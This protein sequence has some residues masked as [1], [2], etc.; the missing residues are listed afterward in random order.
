MR[1]ILF[2]LLLDHPWQPFDADVAG[3]VGFGIAFVAALLGLVG[4]GWRL[5]RKGTKWSA[6]DRANL[7]FWLGLLVVLTFVTPQLPERLAAWLP[8]DPALEGAPRPPVTSLPIFGYG[9][10]VLLGF[11]TG[12]WVGQMRARRAGIDSNLVFDLTFWTL[13]FGVLGG[14]LFYIVQHGDIVFRHAQGIGGHL[15]AAINLSSGG[16]VLIGAMLGGAVGFFGFCRRRGLS[17]LK[18]LDLLTPSIF[19]GEGFGRIGCLLYGCCFG[20]PT[21]LP[22]GVT[23]GPESAAFEALVQRGYVVKSA[24]A[25]MPL[26]PTQ[27]YTSINAFLLAAVTYLYFRRRRYVGDV[28]AL[29]VILYAISRFLIEFV[30]ADELGQLGTGLTISQLLSIGL[31][32]VGLTL[33]AWPRRP[34]ALAGQTIEPTPTA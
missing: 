17:P 15:F 13:I 7:G 18:L 6:D 3:V 21:S 28:F 26:H 27:V 29:G 23:F 22:W 24:A 34:V 9:S 33:A 10:M 5:C 20:D 1:P 11:V 16:L 12:T 14:R 31:F 4:F 25:C 30:R 32:L 19:I 2:R 8:P